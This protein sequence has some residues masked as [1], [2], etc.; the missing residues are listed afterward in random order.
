[1]CVS[2]LCRDLYCLRP[3]RQVLL[4]GPESNSTTFPPTVLHGALPPGSGWILLQ[5]VFAKVQQ[6]GL[7]NSTAV[8]VISFETS[9]TVSGAVKVVPTLH[10]LMMAWLEI[11][12]S[13]AAYSREILFH[14]CTL[15]LCPNPKNDWSRPRV[16]AAPL[17]MSER[18]YVVVQELVVSSCSDD[19]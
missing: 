16:G 7:T 6:S 18:G 12:T 1:M 8:S 15:T 3:L 14:P 4:T 11:L 5:V 17:W 19:L 2:F 10:F 13:L 9:G